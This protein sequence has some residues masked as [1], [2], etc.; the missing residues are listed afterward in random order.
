MQLIRLATLYL[1]PPPDPFRPIGITSGPIQT[2]VLA[3][4]QLE[5][6]LRALLTSH[7]PLSS[8]LALSQDRR[9]A[10]PQ[11]QRV[12]AERE[13]QY[14]GNTIAVREGCKRQI[15][16]PSISVAFQP[17]DEADRHLL[18]SAVGL[19]RNSRAIF[20]VQPSVDLS[21]EQFATVLRDREDGLA[22]LAEALSHEH[23]TG[24][25]HEYLRLFERAFGLGPTDLV[26]PLSTFLEAA[27][28]GFTKSEVE[29]WLLRLRHPTTHAD[30]RPIF[31]LES[32]IRPVTW[33]MRQAAYDVLFNK[34]LWRDDAPSRR[35]GWSPPAW[36]SAPR[37]APIIAREG[38]A[39]RAQLQWLDDFGVFP[40]DFEAE[41]RA[42]IPEGWWV[43]PPDAPEGSA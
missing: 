17:E 40:F 6:R 38:G 20:G 21:P 27:G 15:R 35:D 23:P 32:D 1:V 10:V 42:L 29:D 18:S 30:R 7:V 34:A 36:M 22:L 43:Q 37:E 24:Q 13:I 28:Q 5:G 4:G 3:H 8:P 14:L 16:S 12:D 2:S 11:E 26:L 19:V 31:F 33:R 25:F 9:I 41:V 39:F